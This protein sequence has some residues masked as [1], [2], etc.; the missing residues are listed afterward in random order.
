MLNIIGFTLYSLFNCGLY[1][2]PEVEEEYFMRHPGGLNPVQLNDIVFAL[3]ATVVTLL[4][5]VQCLCYERGGQAVSLI[6]KI[7]VG[8]F[9]LVIIVTIILAAVDVMH[10]LDFLYAC[11]YVKLT[12]TLIKYI[13]QAVMNYKRKSTIGWSI[14]NVV[15]DFTGGILSMLQMIINAD[16][17]NDWASIFGDPTKFGL[18]LFSVLFDIFFLVQ[19]YI[20]YR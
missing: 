19:H 16:N 10:W 15:L 12:I 1:W 5:I 9:V 4:T 7:I 13:P 14:G 8:I 17:Y 3:H 6:G 18:G 20:L 11:S 2:I